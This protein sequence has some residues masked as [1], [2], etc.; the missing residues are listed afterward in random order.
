M[1]TFHCPDLN[2]QL[3]TALEPRQVRQTNICCA[4]PVSG[5]PSCN[6]T[7]RRLPLLVHILRFEHSC[8]FPDNVSGP[9]K[10][11]GVVDVMLECERPLELRLLLE[12]DENVGGRRR[13][14]SSY[15]V[16]TTVFRSSLCCCSAC[17]YR[18]DAT[19]E[20]GFPEIFIFGGHLA[21]SPSV[22]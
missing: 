12:S 3:P 15:P 11:S 2:T 21:S 18:A 5:A 6:V 1:P 7:A 20:P 19:V 14:T 16:S 17:I 4:E 8:S 9:S 22:L 13:C 10:L